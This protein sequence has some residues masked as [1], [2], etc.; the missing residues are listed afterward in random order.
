M[1]DCERLVTVGNLD[2]ANTLVQAQLVFSFLG[3]QLEGQ[4]E[5]LIRSRDEQNQLDQPLV[6]GD[7]NVFSYSPDISIEV[8]TIHSAKGQTHQATLVLETFFHQSDL[9]T[10]L[11]YLAGGFS[12]RPGKYMLTR[13]LPLTYVACTRPSHLLCLAIQKDHVN[14]DQQKKLYE[15]GWRIDDRLA[16]L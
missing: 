2:I 7:P 12:R 6:A 16:V 14:S 15:F 11:P 1:T 4:V 8:N 10:I 3:L 5:A 13:F 9:S